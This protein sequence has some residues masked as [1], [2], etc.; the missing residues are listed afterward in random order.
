[1]WVDSDW[2][3]G[4][5]A[6]FE[7]RL[8]LTPNAR[9]QNSESIT[10]PRA[11][12]EPSRF[13]PVTALYVVIRIHSF[14]I[15]RTACLFMKLSLACNLPLSIRDELLLLGNV[16]KWK[17]QLSPSRIF[18][19]LSS[20]IWINCFVASWLAN[21]LVDLW[22]YPCWQAWCSLIMFNCTDVLSSC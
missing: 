15:C 3:I 2:G 6:F 16:S 22:C 9:W 21:T 17:L 4:S 19:S 18:L 12:S 20:S 8:L 1:M 10:G 11:L 14:C 13:E 7:P 5:F